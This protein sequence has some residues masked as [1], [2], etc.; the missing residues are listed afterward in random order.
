MTFRV[1]TP[2]KGGFGRAP[3]TLPTMSV[4]KDGST[5][6][7]IPRAV[8]RDAG[9]PDLP[10]TRFD[11]L[12]G[13]GEDAGYIAVTKGTTYRAYKVGNGENP[14]AV[15]I[16]TKGIGKAR[17]S[18]KPV[19]LATAENGMLVMRAPDGFP[20]AA[21][22]FDAAAQNHPRTNGQALAA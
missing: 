8:L 11:V 10:G 2:K 3:L 15:C 13:E 5:Q 6:L 19:R 7:A 21:P 17:F 14:T 9:L 18:A 4:F 22:S 12:L 20:F 1:H 16:R